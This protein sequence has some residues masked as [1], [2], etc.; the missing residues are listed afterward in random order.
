MFTEFID[1][2]LTP[3]LFAW[4]HRMFIVKGMGYFLGGLTVFVVLAICGGII[5]GILQAL[6]VDTDCNS[7]VP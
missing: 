4:E 6:G 1:A 2:F 5:E 7:S 3:I